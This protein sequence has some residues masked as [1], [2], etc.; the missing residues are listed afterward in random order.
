[1]TGRER[2]EQAAKDAGF[3]TYKSILM[4]QWNYRTA[5]HEIRV[6]Y[7]K[8][9]RAMSGYCPAEGIPISGKG[10]ADQVIAYLQQHKEK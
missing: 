7:N 1:M 9:D 3:V 4:G 5:S 2:I 8:A 6:K 10:I